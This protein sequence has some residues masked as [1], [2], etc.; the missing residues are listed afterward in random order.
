MKTADSP[1][2]L[3]VSTLKKRR[4]QLLA[5]LPVR[6]K[7]LLSFLAITA[8]SA[9]MIAFFS[10]RAISATL[11]QDVGASLQNAAA[12]SG[13]AVG[14]MLQRQ[15]SALQAFSL[16][17]AVKYKVEAVDRFRDLRPETVQADLQKLDAQWSAAAAGDLFIWS[18]LNN[19]AALELTAY[20]KHFPDNV[21]LRVT[22]KYGGLVAATGR[23]SGYYQADEPWWQAAWNNGQGATYIGQPEYDPRSQSLTIA[24][25]LPLRGIQSDQIIGIIRTTYRLDNLIKTIDSVRLGETGRALLLLPGGQ[26]LTSNNKLAPIDPQ[27]G[28]QLQLLTAGSATAAPAS[29]PSFVSL[30]PVATIDDDPTIA[31]LGWQMLIQQQ[32]EESLAP[33]ATSEQTIFLTSLGAL[34]LAGL[35]AMLVAQLISAPIDRL[36]T[37]AS[38]VAAGDLSRR[39]HMRR[40][41]EIGMLASNFDTM[42]QALAER[43]ANE[44]EAREAAQRLQLVEADN[45]QAIERAV[46]EYLAFVQQVA[47]GDLSQRVSHSSQGALGQLGAGLN[48]MVASLHDI[49]SQVQQGANAIAAAVA[50]ISA[51]TSEQASSSTQQSEAIS[52]TA[53]AIEQVKLIALQTADQATLVAQ[54]SQA[55]LTVA[56]Q[57]DQTVAQTIDS[58]G[59]IRQH[60]GGIAQTIQG[61]A[62]QSRSIS[63]IITAVSELADQIN[64]LAL[65]AAI[66]STRTGAQDQDVATLARLVRELGSQAKQSTGQVRQILSELQSST[67]AAVAATEEGTQRVESGVQLV[68]STGAMIQQIAAELESGALS[69][70]QMAAAAQQQMQGMAQIAQAISSIQQATA[71]TLASTCQAEQAAQS[72]LSLAQS[73]QEAIAV[74]RL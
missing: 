39:L 51:A 40:R 26:L 4:F 66:E 49:T 36:T 46:T 13:L 8:L 58:M 57:S 68:A 69:N 7:L 32:R 43:I 50:Q 31:G 14:S 6:A 38:A 5:D 44:Q 9:S 33:V 28:E 60:V 30:A 21:E 11:T 2:L 42:A 10:N 52:T 34:A 12:Q 70:V 61:L 22:D 59:Q 37:A 53:S 18:H 64:H 67:K 20:S 73:L 74:Y 29:L 24:I 19:S 56:R 25:A 62:V 72:L 65:N 17:K 45:R 55:A 23:T 71:Q 48:H 47:Q 27:L 63:M 35:L 15:A 16:N 54:N 3:P 41:D 1:S